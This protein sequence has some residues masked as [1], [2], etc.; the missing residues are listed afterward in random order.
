MTATRKTKEAGAQPVSKETIRAL[1]TA[2]SF[3]RGRSYFDGGAVSDLCQRGDRLT[4]E[5]EGSE[6][7]PYQVSIRLHE[8]GVADARCT[9]PYDWGGYCKHIVA[10]LLKFA[11]TKTRVVERKP[12]HPMVRRRTW[13]VPSSRWRT[14]ETHERFVMGAVFEPVADDANGLID[15]ALG[16]IDANPVVGIRS[17]G[18]VCQQVLSDCIPIG[19]GPRLDGA[20]ILQ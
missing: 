4:A 10:V 6:F 5:V 11:D 14:G 17:A 2:E 3:A 1:A 12:L 15:Q 9:C 19:A 20:K 7:E 13:Q 18:Q 8:G 16:E